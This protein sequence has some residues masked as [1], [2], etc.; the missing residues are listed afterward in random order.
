VWH[1]SVVCRVWFRIGVRCVV[2]LYC[3][4]GGHTAQ[5][6]L[7]LCN[8]VDRS[9]SSRA[10]FFFTRV[11]RDERLACGH[12][13]P[14]VLSLITALHASRVAYRPFDVYSCVVACAVCASAHG[15]HCPPPQCRALRECRLYLCLFVS[16]GCSLLF[17]SVV[18]CSGYFGSHRG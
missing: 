2:A 15:V 11:M 1:S 4:H 8:D 10:L 3:M 5:C 12:S 13:V 7:R 17:I 18:L 9:I 16:C 14:L 6:T